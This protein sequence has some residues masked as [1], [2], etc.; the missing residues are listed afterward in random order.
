MLNLIAI[1]II[2][3]CDSPKMPSPKFFLLSQLLPQDFSI[4]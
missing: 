4:A 2:E 1:Y 3:T